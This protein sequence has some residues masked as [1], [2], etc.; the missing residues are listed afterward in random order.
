MVIPRNPG[1]MKRRAPRSTP[2]I[3]KSS[4]RLD[5]GAMPAGVDSFLHFIQHI[6]DE[7][8]AANL[9]GNRTDCSQESKYSKSDS[10]MTGNIEAL[11]KN[12][13]KALKERY[14][15]NTKLTRAKRKHFRI[16]LP[17]GNLLIDDYVWSMMLHDLAVIG[18]SNRPRVDRQGL[19]YLHT[20][21]LSTTSLGATTCLY[22]S[23]YKQLPLLYAIRLS[24]LRFLGQTV[25]E[26]STDVRTYK[27]TVLQQ[28]LNIRH[29]KLSALCKTV[30]FFQDNVMNSPTFPRAMPLTTSGNTAE[31]KRIRVDFTSRGI[32]TFKIKTW[33]PTISTNFAP[34]LMQSCRVMCEGNAILGIPPQHLVKSFSPSYTRVC[35]MSEQNLLE[36]FP[37]H[38]WEAIETGKEPISH[39][40]LNLIFMACTNIPFCALFCMK[41][42][43]G[44]HET[45]KRQCEK[46]KEFTKESAHHRHHRSAECTHNKKHEGDETGKLVHGHF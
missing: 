28:R 38:P 6:T 37:L 45:F 17:A 24:I 30:Q 31:Q 42:L 12:G 34:A 10:G 13:K 20:Y 46:F 8:P 9:N 26:K 35:L 33:Q 41:Q 21:P 36:S 40:R 11:K 1:S 23:V 16:V 2:G 18:F 32:Q 29:L 15:H 3:A 43:W 44:S 25:L 7:A 14:I 39:A 27:R 22:K 19:Q 5:T 4:K